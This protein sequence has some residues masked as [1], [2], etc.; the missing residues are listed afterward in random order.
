MV[1][2]VI[3]LLVLEEEIKNVH[4]CLDHLA[5]DFQGLTDNPAAIGLRDRLNIM[6]VRLHE[7]LGQWP[8]L[9]LEMPG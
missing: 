5:R 4:D 8:Q 2:M 1:K 9:G 6:E 7:A 3:N